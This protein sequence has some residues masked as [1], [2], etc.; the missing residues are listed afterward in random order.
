[1][2]YIYGTVSAIHLQH[3]KAGDGR[4]QSETQE[5]PCFAELRDTIKLLETSL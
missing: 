2:H 5:E 1:M 3:I 4:L